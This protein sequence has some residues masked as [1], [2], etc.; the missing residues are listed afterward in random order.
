MNWDFSR[1]ESQREDTF[2]ASSSSRLQSIA[3]PYRSHIDLQ[4]LQALARSPIV[5]GASY[6]L[7]LT[8]KRRSCKNTEKEYRRGHSTQKHYLLYPLAPDV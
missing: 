8:N 5:L 6:C 7:V 2:F 1:W 4:R 3:K